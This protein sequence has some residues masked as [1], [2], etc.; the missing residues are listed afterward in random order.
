MTK[1][2][3]E[4]QIRSILEELENSIDAYVDRVV[5][6]VVP[7]DGLLGPDY[8]HGITVKIEIARKPGRL[9]MKD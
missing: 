2:E 8:D 5:L 9:W 3:A 6:D 4:R 7:S 1:N